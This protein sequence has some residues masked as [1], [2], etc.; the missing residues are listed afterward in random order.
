M[1]GAKFSAP[2]PSSIGEMIANWIVDATPQSGGGNRFALVARAQ[3]ISRGL[4]IA[5]D[6]FQMATFLTN[7]QGQ[8]AGLNQAAEALLR[9]S[10]SPLRI[11]AGH[12][13][14][15]SAG[16]TTA[17]WRRQVISARRHPCC[18]YPKL[19]AVDSS[20]LWSR[21]PDRAPSSRFWQSRWFWCSFPIPCKQHRQALLAQ[22]FGLSP[23]EAQVAARL[24]KGDRIEDIADARRISQETVRAQVNRVCSR[25]PVHAARDS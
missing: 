12:L 10:Q 25:R 11:T 1:D 21:P 23:T 5:L 24:A 17:L 4:S 20:A 15:V 9:R 14:A 8:V 19:T 16:D 18:D 7:R 3:A 2:N 6:H 13:S 22:Q